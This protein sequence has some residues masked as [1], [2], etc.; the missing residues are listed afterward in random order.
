MGIYGEQVLPRII[1]VACGLKPL[2]RLRGRVCQGLPL[3]VAVAPRP[4]TS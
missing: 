3:G 4:L 1:N 2:R